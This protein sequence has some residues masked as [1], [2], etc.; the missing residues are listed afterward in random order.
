MAE[1]ICIGCPK[2]CHLTVDAAT[3]DVKGAGCERGITYGKN[4]MTNPVR[5]VTSTVKI[6]GAALCRVPVKTKN[7]I[8][9][10]KIF[11]VMRALDDIELQAPVKVGDVV[12]RDVCGTGID[13]VVTRTLAKI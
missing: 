9:K 5:V 13:I 8:P 10:D 12:L 4:E 3:L 6:T 11:A 2:G 7:A 1:I